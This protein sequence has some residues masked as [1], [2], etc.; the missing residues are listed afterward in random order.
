MNIKCGMCVFIVFFFSS[1]RR[2]GGVEAFG[3]GPTAA[4]TSLFYEVEN[5]VRLCEM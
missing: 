4:T 2:D 1:L 3:V 5:L